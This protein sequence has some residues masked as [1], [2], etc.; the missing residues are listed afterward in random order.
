MTEAQ[1]GW[2]A[3]IIDG[4]G[5]IT[6]QRS[7]HNVHGYGPGIVIKMTHEEQNNR[8]NRMKYVRAHIETY[9]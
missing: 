5:Y 8:Y 1:L 2:L 9:Q 6:I 3:G 7:G 4:E